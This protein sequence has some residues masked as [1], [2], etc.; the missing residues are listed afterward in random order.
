MRVILRREKRPHRRSR[1]GLQD[2]RRERRL[3]C[4]ASRGVR[5]VDR[6]EGEPGLLGEID[7]ER[8]D[9]LALLVPADADARA[10]E[11]WTGDA[12]DDAAATVRQDD[13]DSGRVRPDEA[14]ERVDDLGVVG[15]PLL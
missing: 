2:R 15:A 7:L 8:L 13:L 11:P 5:A 6:R 1:R 9:A 14:E 10:V 12:G 3:R 4:R